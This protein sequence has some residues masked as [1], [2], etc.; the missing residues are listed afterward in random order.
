[1]FQQPPIGLE[2]NPVGDV[3][4]R[5]IPFGIAKGEDIKMIGG[6]M[7]S[8]LEIVLV[9]QVLRNFISLSDNTKHAARP[10][11]LNTSYRSHELHDINE[12]R[13]CLL[14]AC[15]AVVLL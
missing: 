6:S 13:S 1:M 11:Q 9:L 8:L 5:N 4:K 15:V 7:I 2:P 10:W 14:E 3:E 12:E